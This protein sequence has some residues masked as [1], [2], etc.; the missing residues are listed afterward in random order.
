MEHLFKETL[1]AGLRRLPFGLGLAVEVAQGVA[2][3]RKHADN[4]VRLNSIEA[5]LSSFQRGMRDLVRG[6]IEEVLSTLREPKLD[7]KRFTRVIRQFGEINSAGYSTALFEGL[8][9]DSNH[10]QEFLTT[11]E[12]YGRLLR[13]DDTPTE[14]Q[15]PIF[16]ALG[17]PRIVE[18]SAMALQAL[19]RTKAGLSDSRVV[20]AG[21]VWGLP[22]RQSHEPLAL[23]RTEATAL[24]TRQ[25]V[26]TGS[27][28][29][30]TVN[31]RPTRRTGWH[32][33]K[34][35]MRVTKSRTRNVYRWQTARL[36][37]AGVAI[38]MVYVPPGDFI[39][40]A[41]DSDPDDA[42][43]PKHSHPMPAGY[44][45]GR[46]PIT[47]GQFHAFV[48]ATEYETEAERDGRACVWTG[49]KWEIKS[50]AN[51]KNPYFPQT[52]KHP[53]VCVSHRDATAFCA[54]A[55]LA[56]PTEA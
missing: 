10:Y 49:S 56:L 30:S 55:G 42:V 2:L 8:F 51:W 12:H 24:L 29:R 27:S 26:P 19:L 11:P 38:E 46:H 4:E 47:V 23:A 18:I 1:C 52:Y 28:Q 5:E 43:K 16:L 35:S 13:D 34:L 3:R 15:I 54:W 25:V 9:R 45:V 14:G 17:K 22:A 32:G 31:R 20:A 6:T 48:A 44:Y 50:D 53:V 36:K 41:D 39:M 40:G 33:E 37:A 21:D 7:G